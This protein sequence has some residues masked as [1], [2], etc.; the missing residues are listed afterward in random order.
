MPNLDLE[1][2]ILFRFSLRK[3]DLD[4]EFVNKYFTLLVGQYKTMNPTRFADNPEALAEAK[5]IADIYENDITQITWE[6]IYRFELAILKLE[7]YESLCRKAWILREEYDEIATADEKKQYAASN[8]PKADPAD[9]DNESKLRA[10]LVKIQEELNWAYTVLWVQEDYRSSSTKIIAIVA[11][12]VML[13]F[14]LMA[15]YEVKWDLVSAFLLPN[16]F[17]AGMLG[18]CVST[19]RRI[20][21][22]KFASS[23]DLDLVELERGK[24]S[25]YCSPLLGGIFAAILCALFAGG[26]LEG[27]LFPKFKHDG[28]LLFGCFSLECVEGAKLM[29]WS[30]IAGFAEELVP[31]RLDKLA[32]SGKADKDGK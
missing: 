24:W 30:F 4:K 13:L 6:K 31:D 29:V 7:P 26:L 5:K 18:G 16:V 8:P 15:E 9:K 12:I 1:P 19:L 10:D 3:K 11:L 21:A 27:T 23:S 22:A 17:M 14:G 25:I 32:R 20:Q 2:D 28:E